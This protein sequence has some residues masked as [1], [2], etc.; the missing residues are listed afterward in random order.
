MK[1]VEI[2]VVD[3][4]NKMMHVITAR[5]KVPCEVLSTEGIFSKVKLLE[6]GGGMEA[7]AE[8]KVPTVKV[9]DEP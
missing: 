3:T 2:A 7:N 5:V 6:A 1:K 4:S 9:T 8:L